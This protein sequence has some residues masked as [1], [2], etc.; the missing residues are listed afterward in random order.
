MVGDS[1]HSSP[2]GSPYGSNQAL[3]RV[4]GNSSLLHAPPFWSEHVSVSMFL[5]FILILLLMMRWMY[6]CLN[7][8]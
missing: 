6:F 4:T 5:N 2:S 3:T 8:L 7:A 1:L